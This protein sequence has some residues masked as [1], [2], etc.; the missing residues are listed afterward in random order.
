MTD[1]DRAEQWRKDHA[2][3][4]PITEAPEP[5]FPTHPQQVDSEGRVEPQQDRVHTRPAFRAE[6]EARAVKSKLSERLSGE[7]IVNGIGL[8]RDGAGWAVKVNL[9]RQA[10]ELDL[11]GQVDGVAIWTDVVGHIVAR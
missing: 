1:T 8:A 11:P 6:I 3:Q 5:K 7:R 2:T 4:G 9:V 10:P